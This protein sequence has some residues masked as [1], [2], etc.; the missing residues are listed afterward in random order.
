MWPPDAFQGC[1]IIKMVLWEC[2]KFGNELALSQIQR[3]KD[4]DLESVIHLWR[5]PA[6]K[7]SIEQEAFQRLH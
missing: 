2:T 6:F 5:Q 7:K 4:N 3:P 1:G